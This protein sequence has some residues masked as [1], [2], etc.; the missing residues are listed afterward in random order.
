[1]ETIRKHPSLF[2]QITDLYFLC[3]DEIEQGGS[4]QHEIELCIGSIDE[5]ISEVA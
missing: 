4:E 3:E 5:L 2:E 1:M